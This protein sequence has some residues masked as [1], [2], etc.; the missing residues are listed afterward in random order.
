[1][2]ATALFKFSSGLYVVSAADGERRAGCL[3]NTG[4][5]VT[6]APL[7][8]SVTVNKDNIT[9]GVIRD[10]GHFS[11]AVVDETADMIF[12]GRFGFRSSA[13]FDKFDGIESA[14]AA[15]GDPYPTE[16]VCSYVCCR[17]VQAVD[18][19]TH[20]TFVGEVVDAG[21]LSDEPPMT[22]AYYHGTLKG[23]TPPKASSYVEGVS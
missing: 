4:L 10:A 21:N 9:C 5:Q 3:V 7:Q 6:A 13:D 2:D 17:V 19:G 12:V 22:Y 8:V 14:V 15:T 20:L 18:V 23:K 16:H 11:L 1:M